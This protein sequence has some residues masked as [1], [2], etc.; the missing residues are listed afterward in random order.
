MQDALKM[1][2][3]QVPKGQEKSFPTI[4]LVKNEKGESF[5]LTGELIASWNGDTAIFKSQSHAI[6]P[7]WRK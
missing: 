3:A 2:T 1:T 7:G 6:L 4:F 5:T